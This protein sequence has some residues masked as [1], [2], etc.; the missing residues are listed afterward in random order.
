[1]AAMRIGDTRREKA[2]TGS[3]CSRHVGGGVWRLVLDTLGRPQRRANA[4]PQASHTPPSAFPHRTS[5]SIARV[6]P[7]PPRVPAPANDAIARTHAA[8]VQITTHTAQPQGKRF[9]VCA[10]TSAPN[11]ARGGHGGHAMNGLQTGGQVYVV[12]GH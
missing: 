10:W 8:A 9:A 2:I 3:S 1:M 7:R 4:S 5:P 6:T 12:G 11:A